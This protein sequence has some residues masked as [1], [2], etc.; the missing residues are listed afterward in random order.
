MVRSQIIHNLESA[1]HMLRHFE[2]LPFVL[3]E[4]LITKGYSKADI[5]VSL[6][7][8]GSRF[9]LNFAQ[10]I[11]DMLD[12]L[13]IDSSYKKVEGINENLLIHA[14][15]T[16]EKCIGE[17]GTCG[18]IAI[19]SLEEAMRA[20]IYR[21][22]NRGVE[23]WHLDVEKLPKTN[24]FTVILKPSEENFIFITAFPGPPA[25]PLPNHKMPLNIF[26]FCSKFWDS[27]VFLTLNDSSKEIS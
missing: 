13:F 16:P 4:K 20:K 12:R 8:P 15:V 19:D 25:M 3:E 14:I 22:K 27:H 1:Y 5:K 9:S 6:E 21:K 10:T 26:K 11:E 18:V 17:V 24:N 7:A 23:L 2:C